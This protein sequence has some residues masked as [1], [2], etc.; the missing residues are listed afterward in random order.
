MMGFDWL[1]ALIMWITISDYNITGDN[2]QFY[3]YSIK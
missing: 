3:D 1:T 2:N